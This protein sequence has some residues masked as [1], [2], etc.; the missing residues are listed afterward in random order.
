MRIRMF[1]TGMLAAALTAAGAGAQ[2]DKAADV[3]AAARKAIGDGKVDRVRTLSVEATVQRNV[4]T[5][6]TSSDVE[7]LLELPDK[8]LRSDT[9]SGPMMMAFT[10][11]FNADKVIRPANATMLPGG[12]LMIRM[13]GGPQPPVE[14]PSPEEQARMDAQLL[15][16]AR[17]DISR[18]MLG[19][20]AAAHPAIDA[21]YTYAG[22]AESPD[23]KAHVIDAKSDDGFS[24][25]LFIDQQTM[26]PLM[27]VYQ[28]PQPRVITAGG[29]A[30]SGQAPRERRE[31]SNEEGTR[32]RDAAAQ[33]IQEM[34]RQPPAMAEFTL[35][36]E[37]WRDAGGV[38]FPHKI[39]RAMAGTTHEEWTINKVRVN[40]KIDPKKFDG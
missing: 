13:G 12:G 33:Q 3:L 14:K 15:R 24:A 18:L 26:L 29:P 7:I 1:C 27:V 34:Q 17:G 32:M 9:G 4:N 23:G 20:F 21:R 37:D 25:R 40:P 30:G 22:E 35:F 2:G 8:Y 31:M 6:Q 39:R 11:G 36:F 16:N 5:M 19:W 38:K 10:S 28:G